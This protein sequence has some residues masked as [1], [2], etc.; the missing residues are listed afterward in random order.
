MKIKIENA[1]TLMEILIVVAIISIAS[2]FALREFNKT[3]EK[4]DAQLSVVTSFGQSARERI[5]LAKNPNPTPTP[6]SESE[7]GDGDEQCAS[8]YS[9]FGCDE[10]PFGTYSPGE[11]DGG[12]F[13]YCHGW[14]GDCRYGD[15]NIHKCEKIT[16]ATA[17]P[18]EWTMVLDPS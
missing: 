17:G 18:R 9:G 3:Q 14:K 13:I 10:C 8:S 2:A 1:F 16:G 7:D 5:E 6:S 12:G 15:G 11:G 4:A